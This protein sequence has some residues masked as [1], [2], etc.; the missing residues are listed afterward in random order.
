MSI[1][2]KIEETLEK[3]VVPEVQ[4]LVAELKKILARIEALEKKAAK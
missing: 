4:L 3:S 2:T 1:K